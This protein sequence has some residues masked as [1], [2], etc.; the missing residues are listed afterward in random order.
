MQPHF[1]L[2]FEPSISAI[3]IG[4]NA[5]IM[6]FLAFLVTFQRLRNKV[7]IGDGGNE[8]LIKAIRAHGNNVEY[9][10]IALLMLA[11]IEIMGAPAYVLHLTGG[12]LTFGRISHAYGL[13]GTTGSSAGR[14]L[15]T[16]TT[17]IIIIILAS[18][19]LYYGLR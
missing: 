2:T 9:V 14:M 11:V 1:E 8:A 18:T 13:H 17:W 3:Y 19:C 5:L 10:P 6:L 4:L 12:M 7:D 16:L 15:G